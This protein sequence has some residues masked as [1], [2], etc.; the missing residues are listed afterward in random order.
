MSMI[1]GVSV[2][3]KRT[4]ARYIVGAQAYQFAR[5]FQ[6]TPVNT[7][8]QALADDRRYVGANPSILCRPEAF[9]G[10]VGVHQFTQEN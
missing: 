10:G 5:G 4:Q 3:P 2:V 8:E 1:S 9:S 6:Y 7:F